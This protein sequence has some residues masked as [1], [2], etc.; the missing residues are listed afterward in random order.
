MRHMSGKCKGQ[1]HAP[2]AR[3]GLAHLKGQGEPQCE[4]VVQVFAHSTVLDNRLKAPLSVKYCELW[5]TTTYLHCAISTRLTKEG[6]PPPPQPLLFC[7]KSTEGQLQGQW[8]YS[9]HQWLPPTTPTDQQRGGHFTATAIPV[10][11]YGMRTK[12]PQ[13]IQKNPQSLI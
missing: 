8:P 4:L 13:Y 5:E 3:L 12:N 2:T 7:H 1:L 6:M 11:E 10:T 9:L